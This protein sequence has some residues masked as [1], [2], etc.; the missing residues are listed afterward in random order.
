MPRI[1]VNGHDPVTAVAVRLQSRHDLRQN[2]RSEGI[3]RSSTQIF[4]QTGKFV[5]LDETPST[6]LLATTPP[7]SF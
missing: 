7:N 4:E 1:E 2:R 3:M 5:I 6:L